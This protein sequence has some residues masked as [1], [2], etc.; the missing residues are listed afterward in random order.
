MAAAVTQLLL[1]QCLLNYGEIDPQ[2]VGQNKSLH[3]VAFLSEIWFVH[4][5]MHTMT[6]LTLIYYVALASEV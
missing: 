5:K 4:K 2:M 6:E 1:P 3:S